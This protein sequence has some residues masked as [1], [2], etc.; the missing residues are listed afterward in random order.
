M[1]HDFTRLFFYSFRLSILSF[2]LVL[3]SVSKINVPFFTNIFTLLLYIF[4]FL[5]IFSC[6]FLFAHISSRWK[7]FTLESLIRSS[8]DPSLV[9]LFL[10]S[11][12]TGFTRTFITTRWLTSCRMHLTRCVTLFF[13]LSLSFFF[14]DHLY[15]VC[16]FSC[17]LQAHKN[18]WEVK[19]CKWPGE[20]NGSRKCNASDDANDMDMD[21]V[22]I[23]LLCINELLPFTVFMSVYTCLWIE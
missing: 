18:D 5:S 14:S 3:T 17:S 22:S 6:I 10:L 12:C 19:E 21:M 16:W 7:H 9:S 2:K 15:P 13:L 23:L 20:V 8:L 1:K 4:I 11:L